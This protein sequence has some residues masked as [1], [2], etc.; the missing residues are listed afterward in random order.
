MRSRISASPTAR[1]DEVGED[2]EDAVPGSVLVRLHVRDGVE[3]GP[4]A[5][6]EPFARGGQTLQHVPTGDGRSPL[7]RDPRVAEPGLLERV[8][9]VEAP[10]FGG[11]ETR[12]VALGLRRQTRRGLR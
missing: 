4:R 1:A 10:R 3:D 9:V 11:L 2:A 12:R 7:L 8:R 6:R 5:R